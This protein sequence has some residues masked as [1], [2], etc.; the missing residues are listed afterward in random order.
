MGVAKI[1]DRVQE[2]GNPTN[3]ANINGNRKEGNKMVKRSELV[4]AAKELNSVLGLEPAIDIKAKPEVLT[5]KLQ[6][7]AGLLDLEQDKL[8]DTTL[9]VIEALGYGQSEDADAE[10]P[11]PDDAPDPA[12][13]S[14][15][16]GA[17]KEEEELLQSVTRTS[18]LADLK[19]LVSEHDEFKQL[20]DGL[21]AYKGLSG[22]REL[23]TA[24]MRALRVEVTSSP[25]PA[26]RRTAGVKK[27]KGP[28]VIATIV[29]LIE[30]APKKMGITKPD[31]LVKL[32]TQ[33]PN[34][35]PKAMEKTINVQVPTRINKE[36]FPV[37]K[38]EVGGYFKA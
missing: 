37:S 20:R 19:I 14:E 29:S 4:S 9:A 31:I 6:E 18:K 15:D 26:Q 24:M 35:D 27:D 30:E 25:T 23:K 21:D 5:I 22:P 2:N 36:R 12:P 1:G 8:T 16:F 11:E 7:A 32:T 13:V 17:E 3:L 34:R 38:T 10:A 28:G 33:F